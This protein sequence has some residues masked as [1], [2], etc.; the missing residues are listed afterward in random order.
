VEL[1][2]ITTHE[3]QFEAPV[4]FLKI[5]FTVTQSKIARFEALVKITPG[6]EVAQLL[7]DAFV[8]NPFRFGSVK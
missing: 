2:S 7:S 4:T 6:H 5:T 8:F 1:D 3:L